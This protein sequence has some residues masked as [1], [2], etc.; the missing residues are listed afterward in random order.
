[1]APG[2]KREIREQMLREAVFHVGKFLKVKHFGFSDDG[3]PRFPVGL[4]FRLEEDTP[5][6]DKAA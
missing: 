2:G 6:A 1:V 3:F 4:G 5:A